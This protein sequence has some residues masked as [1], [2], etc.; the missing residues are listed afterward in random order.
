M[1]CTVP[2]AGPAIGKASNSARNPTKGAAK[3]FDHLKS[4]PTQ[5]RRHIGSRPMFGE[6]GFRHG[7]QG[8]EPFKA[9]RLLRAVPLPNRNSHF[10]APT[11]ILVLQLLAKA[12][13]KQG[14]RPYLLV[15]LWRTRQPPIP[16][17]N[18]GATCE[19]G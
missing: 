6:P 18:Y 9:L 7:M 16:F 12:H 17:Q 14:I 5:N 15:P 8:P 13:S 11:N 10:V 2:S 1:V 4:K 3:A 19:V